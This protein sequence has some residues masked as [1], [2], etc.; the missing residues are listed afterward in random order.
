MFYD[1]F[2]AKQPLNFLFNGVYFHLVPFIPYS[3][4][5]KTILVRPLIFHIFTRVENQPLKHVLYLSSL[6]TIGSSVSDIFL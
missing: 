1:E 2:I 6:R 5:A 3:A 4:I